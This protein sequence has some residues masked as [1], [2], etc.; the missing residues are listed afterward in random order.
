MTHTHLCSTPGKKCPQANRLAHSSKAH[1][2]DRP[3]I[4]PAHRFLHRSLLHRNQP[5]AVGRDR[6]RPG[7]RRTS[8]QGAA[9]TVRQK[10]R[11][12]C[13]QLPE[14]G[15]A[16][17]LCKTDSD[18]SERQQLDAIFSHCGGDDRRLG[19]RDARDESRRL[20]ACIRQ[21]K[22]ANFDRNALGD[23][24]FEHHLG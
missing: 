23:Q 6:P 16:A 20:L 21:V 22:R 4:E 11:K 7:H 5:G 15:S 14:T 10:M 3:F 19:D 18:G 2:T 8:K 1:E 17:A 9:G 13:R 24:P 12:R